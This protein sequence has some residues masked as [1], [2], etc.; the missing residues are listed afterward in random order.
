MEASTVALTERQ[1]QVVRGLDHGKTHTL[2]ADEMGVS[3]QSVKTHLRSIERKLNVRRA[4][5]I[6]HAARKAGLL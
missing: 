5:E 1:M 2:I 4:R 3:V 6:P